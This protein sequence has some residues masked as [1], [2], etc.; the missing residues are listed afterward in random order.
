MTLSEEE[1][2]IYIDGVQV[3]TKFFLPGDTL[4]PNNNPLYIGAGSEVVNPYP[5]AG[6][7]DEL[8]LWN[9]TRTQQQINDNKTKVLASNTAG[10][11]LNYRFDQGTADLNNTSITSVVDNTTNSYNGTLNNFALNGATSNFVRGYSGV[12]TKLDQAI[13]FNSL[14]AKTYG[15]AT[16]NLSATSDSGLVVTYTSSCLLYTSDAADE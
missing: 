13:T 11:V 15:D 14:D 10:L 5:F 1:A 12:E 2:K 16:F 9:V 8:R 6:K 3:A 4:T 7:M